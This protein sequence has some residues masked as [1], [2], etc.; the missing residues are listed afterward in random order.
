[1]FLQKKFKIIFLWMFLHKIFQ[2]NIFNGCFCTRFFKITFSGDVFAKQFWRKYFL[3]KFLHNNF[4]RKYFIWKFLH[5]ILQNNPSSTAVLRR[6]RG[7]FEFQNFWD[8][9]FCKLSPT[10]L[11]VYDI[12]VGSL[13]GWKQ[14]CVKCSRDGC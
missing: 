10:V 2:N 7:Q 1:M 4:S 14:K 6:S 3:W 11:V 13:I 9:L 8:S 12:L 5:K